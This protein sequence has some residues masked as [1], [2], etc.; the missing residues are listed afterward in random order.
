MLPVD[1]NF[2][3]QNIVADPKMQCH[4]NSL[5]IW[6]VTEAILGKKT[7]F[8]K[9]IFWKKKNTLS[10]Y[11]LDILYVD[12]DTVILKKQKHPLKCV[13]MYRKNN[14]S[15]EFLCHFLQVSKFVLH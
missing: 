8:L 7:C 5:G 13:C 1:Q 2:L 6:R 12:T 15:G 4:Q 11:F 9:D 14:P 3:T 10:F